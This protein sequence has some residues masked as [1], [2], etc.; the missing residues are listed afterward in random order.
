MDAVLAELADSDHQIIR[1]FTPPLSGA[2][3]DPGYIEAYPPGVRE[4]GGQYTHAATWVVLALAAQN[5]KEDAWHAFE[6]LNPVNHSKDRDSAD[7]YRV[8]PYVVA[9]DIYGD[10]DLT[11]RGGWTWYTGSAAWLYRAA[12]EGI[13]GIRRQGDKLIIRP[14][15]PEGWDGFSAT[16]TI[17]GKTHAIA[18]TKNAK[19]GE[20][21]VSI[22]ATVTKN[23]HEGVLL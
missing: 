8:E 11:G 18:V 1:L 3:Q 16:L 5:R 6:M 12:V 23:A 2:A 10:G 20:P 22:N 21:I 7:H 17:D 19:S 9:A 14:V 15:L 13:L 4:N